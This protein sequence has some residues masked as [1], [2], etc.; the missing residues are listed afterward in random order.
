MKSVASR[1]SINFMWVAHDEL[2][3]Q[4]RE[5]AEDKFKIQ[6]SKRKTARTS[7]DAPPPP[8][9]VEPH[10]LQLAP[11]TFVHQNQPVT[12]I[13]LGALST[14]TNGIAF[15]SV[16]DVLP[17][18]KEGKP[19]NNTAVAVLTTTPVPAERCGLLPVR[20]LRYP[21]LYMPTGEPL[22]IAGSLILLGQGSIDRADHSGGPSIKIMATQ[23][24]RFSV[25]KD[26]WTGPWDLLAEARAGAHSEVP[27]PAP[28]Q[29]R[30]LRGLMPLLPSPCGRGRRQ[31]HHG[32]LEPNMAV[33]RRQVLQARECGLLDCPSPSA[34]IRTAQP[35]G[36]LSHRRTL[37]RTPHI[38]GQGT[39]PGICNGLAWKHFRWRCNAQMQNHAHGD[40]SGSA[41][42]KVWRACA[43][44]RCRGDVQKTPTRGALHQHEG[45]LN[46]PALSATLRHA[47]TQPTK[48]HH[49]MG[50]ASPSATTHWRRSRGQHLGGSSCGTT[51]R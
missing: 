11:N 50:M 40:R 34:K 14:A 10:L 41:T 2:Q 47:A 48:G 32:P 6:S 21:A 28:V 18:L 46:L 13:D 9:Q 22:L 16:A 37:C 51:S 4:I 42:P 8:L 19:I 30:E 23:T 33:R 7:K 1:P 3:A 29:R 26:Q 43:R 44:R 15:G 27:Y 38:G 24:L 5:K 20:H 36:A 49:E 39:R 35:T 17:Y 45:N 25:Y 12:Q 31:C